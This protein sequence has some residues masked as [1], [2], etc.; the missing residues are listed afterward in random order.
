MALVLATSLPVTASSMLNPAL[1]KEE[2]GLRSAFWPD[3]HPPSEFWF[4]WFGEVS[5]NVA[6]WLDSQNLPEGSVLVDTFGV[7]RVWLESKRPEQFVVRS[8]F[9]F[10]AKLNAPAEQGVQYILTQRPTGLGSL[11]AINVRYPTLWADGAGIATVAMTV[12][13]PTGKPQFRIY[14]IEGAT[15]A[16]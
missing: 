3:R 5:G 10:F 2:Y 13:T 6:A 11:D 16:G 12:T 7:S 8:D 4:Y 14:R 15:A 9:D 1:G